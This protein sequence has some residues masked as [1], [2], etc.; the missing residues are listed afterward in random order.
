M[1]RHDPEAVRPDDAKEVR[2]RR[3]EHRLP[4]AGIRC[5]ARTEH[6]RAPRAESAELGYDPR[7]RGRGRHD[8]GKFRSVENLADRGEPPCSGNIDPVRIDDIDAA[9]EAFSKKIAKNERAQRPRSFGRPHQK[10][11]LRFQKI[12]EVSDGHGPALDT[13]EATR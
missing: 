4:Q 1:R 3:V 10:K 7:H 6:D 9:F 13:G 2:S 5:D 11:A 12:L 8:D